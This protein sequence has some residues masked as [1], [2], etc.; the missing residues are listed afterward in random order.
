METNFKLKPDTYDGNGS[1]REFLAQFNLI[2]YANHWE[3]STKA[4]VLASCLR[5]KARAILES[6][7]NLG[8]LEFE[9]LKSKLELRFGDSQ[10]A[11]NYYSQF[12]N[13]KQKFGESVAALGAD[14]D[15]LA[16][17]AYSECTD[18]VR[19]KIACAQ[20]VSALSN[21]FLKRTL[22][23]EGITSLR[24][25]IERAKA[26]QLIQENSFDKKEG[27]S[28]NFKQ[29]KEK[30]EADKEEENHK[31]EKGKFNKNKFQKVGTGKDDK[32]IKN[33]RRKECWECGKEGHFRAECPGN[34]GNTE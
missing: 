24:V 6:V 15:R 8:N 4:A 30:N 18:S 20:F 5:G 34:T 10:S 12:T 28:F 23:L 11:Q 16:R 21:G 22:Q 26:I 13:R 27:N 32:E 14:I 33:A 25:A 3:N 7:E 29:G 2:A 9:E 17:L 31:Q 19:E 1:L